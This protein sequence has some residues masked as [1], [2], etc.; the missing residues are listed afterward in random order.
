M[1]DWTETGVWSTDSGPWDT[2]TASWD[3][4]I[5]G[6]DTDT[7]KWNEE[8]AEI[9]L[10]MSLAASV[11][12]GNS[13]H[14][15]PIDV[16][17]AWLVSDGAWSDPGGGPW[18]QPGGTPLRMVADMEDV[19]GVQIQDE[20]SIGANVL[21]ASGPNAEASVTAVVTV[22]VAA[23]PGAGAEVFPSVSLSQ[24][25]SVSDIGTAFGNPG[26]VLSTVLDAQ[27]P[28][29]GLTSFGDVS[30]SAGMGISSLNEK[31]SKW[32][33]DAPVTSSWV[34]DIGAQVDWLEES[35]TLVV[36]SALTSIEHAWV[37]EDSVSFEWIKLDPKEDDWS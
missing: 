34:E 13:V 4:A 1:S 21:Q 15:N 36:W 22:T 9:L 26:I 12:T 2:D 18:D 19:T 28:Q 24:M 14:A 17:D 8:I 11:E 35:K 25:V 27:V 31:L 3:G 33:Q 16:D 37:D 32:T 29:L 10:D 7:L 20:V 23:I 30:L 5:G 6:W